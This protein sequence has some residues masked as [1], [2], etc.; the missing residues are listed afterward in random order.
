MKKAIEMI[1]YGFHFVPI[2]FVG[3]AKRRPYDSLNVDY[4]YAPCITFP[5]LSLS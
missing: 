2:H 5:F 1:L 3:A 4:R